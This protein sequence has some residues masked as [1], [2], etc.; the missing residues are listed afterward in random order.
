MP[1]LCRDCHAWFTDAPGLYCPGCGGR[2][3]LAHAELGR[4]SI[5][6]MDCDAFYA[7]VE[8]R[9]DPSLTDKPV[10]VGGGRRG[11]V[12]TCC[13]IARIN[14]V[15]SAMPMF[16]AL[17]LC[18]D[19]VVLKPRMEVYAGVSKQIRTA[20][21]RLT[22]AVEPLSL[23]EAFLDLTGTERLLGA[24]P[25]VSLARLAGEIERD[26]GIT[27]SIGLSHCKFLAKIASDLDK[28]RGFQVIGRAETLAF[29]APQPV[30]LIWG[31][32]QGLA[33]KLERDGIRRI[34]DLR[35]HTAETLT[36]RYGSMGRRLS[37]LSHGIDHRR[38]QAE[39]GMK[40]ISS[41]TTFETDTAERDVLIGH[42]WRLAVRTSDRAK[43]K[44]M[45]GAT[46]TLKLKT[47]GFKTLTRQLRLD[48]PSNRADPI[49]AA[50]AAMLDQV[51]G[52]GPFRLIGI[53][54]STL[55]DCEDAP[56]LPTGLFAE[57]DAAQAK[58]EAATDKIRAKFGSGAIIR[59]RALR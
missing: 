13:Y 43:A 24:P 4:L 18:P 58:A 40:S 39:R 15:R 29:L 16:K 36:A 20:M 50:G 55:S 23:D 10:I 31:V 48:A 2:R 57:Q 41:E 3:V 33:A 26:I 35:A 17:K 28:P 38:V 8:K 53:G 52:K 44:S 45:A 1:A 51:I 9:D 46:V 42:L 59:G 32:G 6:H 7:A 19:A 49:F 21:E 11:V 34:A 47:A 54:L 30:S 14:G 27:I 12:S 22:P 25:A 37:E 5:A 56:A